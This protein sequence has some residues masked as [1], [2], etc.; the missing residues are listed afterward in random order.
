MDIRLKWSRDAGW[1]AGVEAFVH[2]RGPDGRQA[3]QDGP[4]RIFVFY[5][6]DGLLQNGTGALDWRQPILPDDAELDEVWEIVIGLYDPI[7]GMR[8]DVLDEAGNV[9]GNE[10]RIGT[11]TVGPPTRTRSG[12]CAGAG[13]LCIAVETLS[14]CRDVAMQRL[15]NNR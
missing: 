2:L 9:V 3:Q 1:P 8:L 10:A 4:P 6:A 5:D 13:D 12:L 11:I 7:S 15:Y 14:C